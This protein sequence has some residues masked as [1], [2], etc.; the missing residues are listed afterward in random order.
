VLSGSGLPLTD[1][2]IQLNP[3]WNMISGVGETISA[4]QVQDPSGVIVEG[5]LTG[6][7]GS[8]Q[9]ASELTPGDAYWVRA[10]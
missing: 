3:G 7:N 8:Y 5:T 2:T 4:D 6:F 10:S 1:V 9:E